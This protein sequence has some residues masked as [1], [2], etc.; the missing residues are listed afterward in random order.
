[1]STLQ[2]SW[3]PTRIGGPPC[4]PPCAAVLKNRP[5]ATAPASH[6][7]SKTH[8]AGCGNTG[9]RLKPPE[10]DPSAKDKARDQGLRPGPGA[11]PAAS[12]V[13]RLIAAHSDLLAHMDTLAALHAVPQSAPLSGYGQLRNPRVV[14]SVRLA[15]G[16]I[17]LQP[18]PAAFA[19]VP[20]SLPGRHL[21]LLSVPVETDR[22]RIGI[23]CR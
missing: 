6:A 18:G 1:M 9:A 23:P 2:R 14:P 17:P 19:Q 10:H 8:A 15:S 3:P 4:M 11:Q 20:D 12:E 13:S 7:N 21:D 22:Q 16:L 5:S